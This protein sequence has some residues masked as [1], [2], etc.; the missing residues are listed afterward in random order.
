MY[1][2]GDRIVYRLSKYSSHPTPRAVEIRPE[3][4]GECY[5]YEVLKYWIVAGVQPDGQIVAV[6]RR[7]K[8]RVIHSEDPALRHARW[9]ERLFFRGRFPEWPAPGDVEPKRRMQTLSYE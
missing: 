1:K 4:K 7:G 6:T 8:R 2:P 5:S 9:W 3:P